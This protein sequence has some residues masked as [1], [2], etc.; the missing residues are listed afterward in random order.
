[1]S[2]SLKQLGCCGTRQEGGQHEEKQP[3]LSKK[4][5][6]ED[7]GLDASFSWTADW[8]AMNWAKQSVDHFDAA[9]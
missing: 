2:F 4:V 1:M 7:T 5:P 8:L 9:S 6:K 3:Q